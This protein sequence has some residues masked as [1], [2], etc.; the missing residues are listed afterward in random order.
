M[1]INVQ[2]SPSP[3]VNISV[4]AGGNLLNLTP[5]GYTLHAN[6]HISGGIDAI[7]HNFLLGLQGGENNQ[8]YHL[9]SGQYVNL[10]NII[11][12]TGTYTL[13]SETGAFYATSNPSGFITGINNIVYDFG[14]QNISGIKNFYSRP[15]V[16]GTGV[17]LI[18]EVTAQSEATGVS[19]YLQGQINVLNNQTGSYTLHSETG[20]FY[21]SS[22]PSG[23]ITGINLSSYATIE[24]VTGISGSLQTQTTFLNNQTGNYALKSN[25]GLFL[26]TGTADNRYVTLD[27]DQ[28]IYNTKTFSNDVYINR[29]FVTG[30]ETIASTTVSNIQSPYIILNLTGGATDG[31][32]FFITGAGLTGIN[33]SGPI[34]GFD[35]SDQF[36][37]GISTRASD[38]STL[39]TIGSVEQIT[40]LSGYLQPQI[41]T[42]QNQTGNYT[43][44]SET[45]AFYAV[46]NPSGFITGVNL[47]SYVTNSQTG[48]F[49][50]VSNPSGFITG[51][52]LSSYATTGYVTGISGSLQT[53]ITSLSNQSG[54]AIQ[55]DANLIISMSVFI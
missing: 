40:G 33:D 1:S 6:T 45:G 17:L 12:S 28:T 46:S 32:M 42:L 15:T 3:S 8:Y 55:D 4:G 30:S 35:H 48:A 53:Q 52:D 7:D 36:K 11:S 27:G 38:L 37:F 18:G 19:G 29:L 24:Y 2:V 21:A 14:N 26:T 22:N 47:S 41:T 54:N 34:I 50:A 23:F 39:A 43:L 10:N 16:N 44:H 9:N 49:Y 31:G 25:T 20:V 51:I 13:H 5:Q